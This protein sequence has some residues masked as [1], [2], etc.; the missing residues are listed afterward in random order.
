MIEYR[1]K[2]LCGHVLDVLRQ[3]PDESVHCVI[4][5][6]PYW[7]LRKYEGEEQ[8]QVWDGGAWRGQLG[9][10]PTPDLYVQHLV[11]MFREV[12]RVLR[13]D[14]TF[15]LNMGDSYAAD[16]SYQVHNTIGAKQHT[17]SEGSSVPAGLKPKDL[18][19]IPWRVAFALQKDGWY[20]RSDIIWQKPN[21]MPESINGWRWQQHRI[22]IGRRGRGK[23]KWRVGSAIGQPQQD[24]AP[25]GSFQ[26]DV[27]WK[28][29]PGCEKCS[30]NGGLILRKGSWRPTKAHEY[31]F[32]LT[33]TDS[34][35]CDADAIRE[36]AQDWGSRDRTNF[37]GGT[38]DPLLKHHGLTK[39]DFASRGRNKRS[40]WTIPTA[41][42]KGAHFAV[43]P[44]KLVEPMVKAGTSE[45]GCCVK[46]GSPWTRVT[47]RTDWK[48][49]CNCNTPETVPAIVLDPFV[50]SG[51]TCVVAKL[52][53][54][55][56]IGIDVSE[57]YCKM[58]EERIVAETTKFCILQFTL[59]SKFRLFLDYL[60]YWLF[61]L[62]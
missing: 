26:S 35:F 2:I 57:K 5:S 3:L 20:L 16:R 18:V 43:F 22:K 17:Y 6:P 10:E 19:G 48:P 21:P 13:K 46:C 34:Y 1:N 49:S 58:A 42:F 59:W 36:P 9:L 7:G 4:T 41:S 54:R 51:T 11:E 39:G 8:N 23:E 62:F 38:A 45:K 27:I 30:P 56:Y 55:D 31:V 29:C 28:E 44:K 40:V 47:G 50:G 33:K 24:H 15:W 52:L 25:D 53:G 61:G 32:Q 14:G 60:R 12:R 37:R